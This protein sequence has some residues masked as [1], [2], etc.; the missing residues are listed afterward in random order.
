M[1]IISFA[2]TSAQ[3]LVS[4]TGGKLAEDF[5]WQAPFLV[6]AA[7]A[8][9]GTL[10]VA[11]VRDVRTPGLGSPPLRRLGRVMWVPGVLA[12]SLIGALLQYNTFST[13]YSFIPLYAE[14]LGASKTQVGLL[15]TAALA[16]YVLLTLVTAGLSA[17]IGGKAILTL[18]L[19]TIALATLLTPSVHTLPMLALLQMAGGAGRGLV[20]PTLMA[21]SIRGVEVE[22]QATAMGIFQA[23]YAI[24]M[25]GGP[26]LSG[27]VADAVGLGGVFLSTGALS[28]LATGLAV[29]SLG[30]GE[31]AQPGGRL[32][33][34]PALRKPDGE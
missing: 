28:L 31:S 26:I 2:G 5:G 30:R 10:C 27:V 15:L 29:F 13:T 32:A 22:D 21:L 33:Y 4:L 20:F 8:A 25:F 11:G 19:G 16:P 18:G 6:G 3:L 7:M 1:A 17:R 24:G 34:G 23:V 12:V 14:D 9:L